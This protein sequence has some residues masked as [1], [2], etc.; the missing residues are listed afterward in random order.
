VQEPESEHS[1]ASRSFVSTEGEI[2]SLVL[3]TKA[4]VMRNDESLSMDARIVSPALYNS[5]QSSLLP[6]EAT[7][8]NFVVGVTSA[9]PGDGKTTVAANLAISMA[10]GDERETLLVDL[11]LRRPRL[12][13]VFAIGIRPGL[14]EALTA[15]MA[16]VARTTVRHLYVMTLGNVHSTFSG[17][18]HPKDHEP[19]GNGRPHG[20]EHP[21]EATSLPSFRQLMVA[22]KQR[23]HVIIFDMPAVSDP[24]LPVNLTRHM[25]GMLFVV[26]SRTT[27]KTDIMRTSQRLGKD[28][29]LGFVLNRAAES[30]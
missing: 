27:T 18:K 25:D 30:T 2:R 1:G 21:D 12:H 29:I 8:P 9:R 14:A 6:R 5:F 11:N 15:P 28:R 19:K 3:A 26:D 7:S 16:H 24:A 10:T 4:V 22:L 23:F 13:S 17:L 20:M